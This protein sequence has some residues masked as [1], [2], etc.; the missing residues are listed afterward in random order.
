M[1]NPTIQTLRATIARLVPEAM[2]RAVQSYRGFVLS[3]GADG[4]DDPKKF[5]D[6]HAAGRSALAHLEVLLRLARWSTAGDAVVGGDREDEAALLA[7]VSDA[8]QT[9]AALR[10]ESPD[11]GPDGT[12]D[13][14]AP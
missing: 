10:G 14:D 7:M 11:G 4:F 1:A 3:G 13:E 5:K 2:E 9:L 8:R 12:V 6:H